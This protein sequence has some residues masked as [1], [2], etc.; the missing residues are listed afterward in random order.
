MGQIDF[1][2]PD[3]MHWESFCGMPAKNAY[4]ESVIIRKDQSN[5]KWRIFLQSKI[6]YTLQKCKDYAKQR[7]PEELFPDQRRLNVA[8][9]WIRL[10]MH[11]HTHKFC[12]KGL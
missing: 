1:M 2:S 9:S 7:K 6:A 12:Y 4:P 10:Y 8:W 11:T 3:K 5:Q